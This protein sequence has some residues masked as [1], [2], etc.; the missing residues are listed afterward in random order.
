MLMCLI[1]SVMEHPEVKSTLDTRVEHCDEL[2]R[3]WQ[4][5]VKEFKEHEKQLMN[6]RIVRE[7]AIQ[8]GETLNKEEE[9]PEPK[10]EIPQKLLEGS[11]KGAFGAEERQR[12]IDDLM[13]QHARAH[14]QWEKKVE[15]RQ[16]QEEREE[17]KRILEE[18]R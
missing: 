9:E 11:E 5:K 6:D 13:D 12:K 17:D 15:H 8:A 14:S 2:R 1:D 4:Q 3:N 10:L 18:K 16:K 7:A